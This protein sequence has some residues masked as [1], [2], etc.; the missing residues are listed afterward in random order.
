L[1]FYLLYILHATTTAGTNQPHQRLARFETAPDDP[2]HGLTNSELPLITQR[3]QNVGLD[4]AGDLHF[5][6][7][8]Y[9]YISVGDEGGSNDPYNNGQRIDK[10]FFAAI[11]RIDVD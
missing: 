5:G 1:F 7:D 2:N 3:D 8:G 9:L 6:P 4:N 10:N 11:L